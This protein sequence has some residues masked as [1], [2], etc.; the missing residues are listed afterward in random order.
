M[1]RGAGLDRHPQVEHRPRVVAQPLGAQLGQR[2]RLRHE[3][4]AAPAARRGEVAALDERRERLAQSRAG[5]P[6][7]VGERSL[8]GEPAARG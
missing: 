7:L 4:A 6:E 2:R 5:D 8:G 3:G 1:H